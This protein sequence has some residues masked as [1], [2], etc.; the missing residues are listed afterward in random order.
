[1]ETEEYRNA[2]KSLKEMTGNE[3]PTTYP[4]IIV[5]LKWLLSE[6]V[7]IMFDW[8]RTDGYGA[9]LPELKKRYPSL[10]DLRQ[11]LDEDSA[12]KK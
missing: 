12:W 7:S 6:K 1:M 4:F 9:N 11:C 8:F 5:I 3:I 2:A 10:K